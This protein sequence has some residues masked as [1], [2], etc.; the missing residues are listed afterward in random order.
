MDLGCETEGTGSNYFVM[1]IL[2]N[3]SYSSI[4]KKLNELELA[5]KISFA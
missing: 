5:E 2:F 1:E 3:N 4:Y